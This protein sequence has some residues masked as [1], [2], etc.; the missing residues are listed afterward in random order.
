[1]ATYCAILVPVIHLCTYTS[2]Q[3]GSSEARHDHMGVERGSSPSRVN[4]ITK[5]QG[6]NAL[7]YRKTPTSKDD[8]G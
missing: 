4:S 5:I 2:P 7:A 8:G 3:A 1:M 6:V